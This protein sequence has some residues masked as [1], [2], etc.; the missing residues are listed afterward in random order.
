MGFVGGV[1][2]TAAPPSHDHS[3]R[4]NAKPG[5]IVTVGVTSR[6]PDA[7]QALSV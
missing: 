3:I 1:E 2:G 4:L 7:S 6:C 5:L